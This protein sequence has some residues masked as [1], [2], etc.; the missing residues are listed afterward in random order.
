MALPVLLPGWKDTVAVNIDNISS[1]DAGALLRMIEQQQQADL[2]RSE[3]AP[4]RANVVA[5][6]PDAVESPA[7]PEEGPFSTAL[8][9]YVNI[10]A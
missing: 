9:R 8:G 7:S 6:A 4:R 5:K 1:V 3:E 10:F 2:V